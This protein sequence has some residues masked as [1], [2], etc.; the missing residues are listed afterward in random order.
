MGDAEYK[1]LEVLD[2]SG[3]TTLVREVKTGKLYIKKYV[4]ILLKDVYIKLKTI[5]NVHIPRVEK[6]SEE[7]SID[8]NMVCIIFEEYVT[9]ITFEELR[10][11]KEITESET[12]DYMI[13]L[14]NALSCIHKLGIIHRDIKPS[15][16]ILNC[17]GIVKLVDF[18]IARI[19][20]PKVKEDTL[21][22]GTRGY[23][24]P[25]QY[26]F[27][28][29][30]EYTDIYAVGVLMNVLLT[31]QLPTD[32]Q[33]QGLSKG[34]IEKC[35]NLNPR[36]RFCN[37]EEL[38]GQLI[39]LKEKIDVKD[40]LSRPHIILGL[41]CI[42]FL[43]AVILISVIQNYGSQE[44]INT[45]YVTNDHHEKKAKNL[46]SKEQF[47]FQIRYSDEFEV[48]GE[49]KTNSSYSVNI[50]N[51]DLFLSVWVS[52]LRIYEG[53]EYGT[54]EEI[55]NSLRESAG[56][57]SMIYYEDIKAK[58][59]AISY[60]SAEDLSTFYKDSFIQVIRHEVVFR[61]DNYLI[62]IIAEIPVNLGR[63]YGMVVNN[64]RK[65]LVEN[66]RYVDKGIATLSEAERA[67]IENETFWIEESTSYPTVKFGRDMEEVNLNE[68][69]EE[70]LKVYEEVDLSEEK[71]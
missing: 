30:E 40:K 69:T 45:I 38:K 53:H 50:M 70:T 8:G 65:S 26:G 11:Q 42:I 58:G 52:A 24:A 35:V 20:K 17:D 7:P 27:G 66:E 10:N 54:G 55:F 64:L 34:I 62:S 29:S 1:E 18:G 46:F 61:R 32:K 19:A 21:L 31:E 44:E 3:F 36:D 14:C 25:E 22:L 57:Y 59:A 4:N 12:L 9:G 15:N 39:V 16:I 5:K 71:E 13:Q 47:P 41:M 28:Q 2:N 63:E 23:A 48:I 60:S 6:I 56:F 67:S 51:R 37:V 68:Y 49:T 43:S 33:Y